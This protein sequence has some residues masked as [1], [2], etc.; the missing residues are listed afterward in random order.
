[1]IMWRIQTSGGPVYVSIAVELSPGWPDETFKT[2]WPLPPRLAEG[3]TKGW[4]VWRQDDNGNQY[5]MSRHDTQAEAESVA[6]DLEARG[7]KQLYWV[8][9]S[10]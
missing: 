3:P 10:G 9:A 1:M 6:A 8:A 5:V 7:H 2:I 4:T